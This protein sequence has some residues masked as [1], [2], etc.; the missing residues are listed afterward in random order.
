MIEYRIP[1]LNYSPWQEPVKDKDLTVPPVTPAKGDQYIVGVEATGDWTGEDDN[2]ALWTGT[3][4]TFVDVK[5]GFFCF[6]EDEDELYTFTTEWIVFALLYV[7]E[8]IF[9]AWLATP[10]NISIFT[11]D[12]GY[13][14]EET[15][16]LS[17][18]LDQTAPQ[19]IINGVPL[20]TTA[21]D[22]Y[23]S[24]NQLVNMC[25]VRGATWLFPPIIE[26]YD[27]VAEEGLPADPEVGDRYGADSTGYGWTIDYIYEWDGDEWVESEPEDGWM[28][29]C[30]FELMFYVF[31]SGGW[32]EEGSGSYVPYTGALY[33][34]D[35]GTKNLLTEGTLGA[36]AIT[37]T[38]FT[39]GA[40]TLTIDETASLT[41][42]L[43]ATLDTDVSGDSTYSLTN[44]VNGTFSGQ[45]SACDFYIQATGKIITADGS[46]IM[47]R[48][49]PD[50]TIF[51]IA[52]GA[53]A[54]VTKGAGFYLT[55]DG[56]NPGTSA[57]SDFGILS[58]ENNAQLIQFVADTAGNQIVITNIAN[59]N[60]NHDHATQTNPTLYIH[61]DTSPDSNNTQWISV[62]HNQ[63]NGVI[64]TGIGNINLSPAGNV[65]LTL[66]AGDLSATFGGALSALE[67]TGSKFLHDAA[68]YI[69]KD[70]SNNMIFVDAVTGSKTLAEL[71]A[72]GGSGAPTDATYIV[73]TAHAGLS[74]EQALGALATG[75]LKNTT[76]TGVLSIAVAGTD[77]LIPTNNYP[78][79]ATMWHDEATVITGNALAIIYITSTNIASH[80][81]Q[82]TAADGDSF[83]NSFF[84]KA[85]TYTFSVIGTT[86]GAAGRADW[87]IDGV[88]EVSLQD[89]YG[90]TAWGVTKTASVTVATDGY[91][92]LIGTVNGKHASSSDYILQLTKYWF[93]PATDGARE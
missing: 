93:K 25:Y 35:L 68:T 30:L 19:T 57:N 41:D 27:P 55:N 74:A 90:S 21:V 66:D 5:R 73:Q 69:D 18:H 87:Y 15:D 38:S 82:N 33:D 60:M 4:W 42:Y 29:W 44:M 39:T 86:A 23:G 40:F 14:T 2:I 52:R 16:P 50:N 78:Q 13:L 84:L 70:G 36:G 31:F 7:D 71:A 46:V 17:L 9:S 28:I 83:S 79:R 32:M 24:C 53:G 63:T 56:T 22:E 51:R 1:L 62:T 11:N 92:Q 75:I 88:K 58:Q 3:E 20:M 8:P 89:W 37:G 6:V 47:Q 72:A 81:Y 26:W 49:N 67:I 48:D 91:H 59:R 61:S 77:Y 80:A 12:A 76:T 43:Q 45:I 54:A 85:G 65:A 34:V 10:P 64:E